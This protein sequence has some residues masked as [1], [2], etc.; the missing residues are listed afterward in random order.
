MN[1]RS[2]CSRLTAAIDEAATTA[3]VDFAIGDVGLAGKP[4]WGSVRES[5]V[6]VCAF[7]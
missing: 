4:I 1:Q 3:V 7:G 5:V 2:T 6:D